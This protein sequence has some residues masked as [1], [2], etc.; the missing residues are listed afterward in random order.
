MKNRLAEMSAKYEKEWAAQA[1]LFDEI[2]KS[3]AHAKQLEEART[4]K[5]SITQKNDSSKSGTDNGGHSMTFQFGFSGSHLKEYESL[6]K[7]YESLQAKDSITLLNI[8]KKPKSK[9]AVLL[10]RFVGITGPLHKVNELLRAKIADLE[11][12]E[13]IKLDMENIFRRTAYF[14]SNSNNNRTRSNV[15]RAQC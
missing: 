2:K 7:R 14:N 12:R 9:V 11:A 5:D 6:C 1:K 3:E 4:V 13:K 8:S 15:D 10:Y